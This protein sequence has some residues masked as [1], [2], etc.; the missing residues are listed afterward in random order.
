[1]L[2]Y[3]DEEVSALVKRVKKGELSAFE[4]LVVIYEKFVYGTV[5]ADVG[6]FHDAEDV[7]QEVFLKAWKGI[8]GYR[9]DSSFAS[10]LHRIAK[11]AAC[12]FMR[13]Q[14]KRKEI[15]E[16]PTPFLQC[17]VSTELTPEE[18]LLE[19]EGFSNIEE[20]INSLPEE[21]R[22]A[23]I[24]RDLMGITYLEIADITGVTVGTVKS[25]ISRGRETV[26]TAIENY[27]ESPLK[28]GTNK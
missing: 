26:K 15:P 23:L 14:Q 18:K 3:T 4:E 9:G 25:R 10:W 22:T 2:K 12:D 8:G 6:N 13:K 5:L 24:Y 27:L 7:S 16:D 20:I 17:V 28:K 21:Q 11:N 19:A 1:M